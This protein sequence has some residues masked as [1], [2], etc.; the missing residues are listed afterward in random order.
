MDEFDDY[1]GPLD[2]TSIQQLE[3][4]LSQYEQRPKAIAPATAARPPSGPRLST[5]T[6][7]SLAVRQAR[8]HR[9]L[10]AHLGLVTRSTEK[11]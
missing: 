10:F 7:Q 5:G 2:E 4:Q 8:I 9:L 3:Q 1:F 11:D 6:D